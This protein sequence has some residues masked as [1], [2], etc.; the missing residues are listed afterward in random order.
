MAQYITH[1]YSPQLAPVSS[2]HRFELRAE[3]GYHGP[4][5]ERACEGVLSLFINCAHI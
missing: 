3:C 1:P 2:K 5:V 4:H